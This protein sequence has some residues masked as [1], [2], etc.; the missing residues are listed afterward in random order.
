[1]LVPTLADDLSQIFHT[2]THLFS[3][4]EVPLVHEVVPMM[5]DL[6]HSLDNVWN[7]KHRQ[8][9]AVIRI[10]AKAALKVLGKYYALSDDSEVYRIAIVMCPDKKVQWFESNPDWRLDDAQ[11]VRRIVMRRW[12]DSYANLE[13]APPKPTTTVAQQSV[14]KVFLVSSFISRR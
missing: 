13:R 2:V 14:P 5:E 10:A 6:E 11:E 4:A 8:L 7:Q 3:R 9:P 12:T 1:V